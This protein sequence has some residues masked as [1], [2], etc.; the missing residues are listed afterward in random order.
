MLIK[1]LDVDHLLHSPILVLFPLYVKSLSLD[2]LYINYFFAIMFSYTF[3]HGECP[4]SYIC[5]IYIDKNYVAGKRISYYPEMLQ[6]FSNEAQISYYFF[7]MTMMY[8]FSLLYVI[9]RANVSFPALA[10]SSLSIYF[11]TLRLIKLSQ[12]HFFYIF[13]QNITRTVLFFTI[14]STGFSA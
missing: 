2:I 4:I 10:F 9:Q 7:T 14:I 13:I 1:A 5:K 6:I 8:I 3:I 12:K 11:T